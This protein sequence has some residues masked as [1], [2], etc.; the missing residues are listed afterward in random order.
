MWSG[1]ELR[2]RETLKR[3]PTAGTIVAF[4]QTATFEAYAPGRRHE[5]GKD[6]RDS[7]FRRFGSSGD[8]PEL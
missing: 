6:G 3:C 7:L 8:I 1:P 4:R 2:R 5:R